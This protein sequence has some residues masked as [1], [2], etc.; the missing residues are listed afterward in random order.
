MDFSRNQDFLCYMLPE[1]T[2]E[3]CGK[4]DLF[5]VQNTYPTMVGMLSGISNRGVIS[6]KVLEFL[7]ILNMTVARIEQIL[8]K[9]E[10][11]KFANLF[12]LEQ[13]NFHVTL[14]N[15]HAKDNFNRIS[16]FNKKGCTQPHCPCLSLNIHVCVLQWTM[17]D[18]LVHIHV[19]ALSKRGRQGS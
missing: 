17:H 3:C 16:H 6:W 10:D 14:V 8:H 1:I 18:I 9:F 19:R 7:V 11:Q 2:D 4:I 13:V 15:C 5:K 12:H